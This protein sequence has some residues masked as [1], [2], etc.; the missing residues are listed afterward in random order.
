MGGGFSGGGWKAYH[1]AG[2]SSEEGSTLSSVAFYNNATHQTGA[3]FYVE[4]DVETLVAPPFAKSGA[5]TY[6]NR[7]AYFAPADVGNVLTPL[8]GAY[9]GAVAPDGLAASA[10]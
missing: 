6:D 1:L 10:A 5:A 7:I 9:K 4:R 8:D 3:D 2:S